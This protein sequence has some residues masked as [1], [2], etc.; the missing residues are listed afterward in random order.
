MTY[1]AT[2]TFTTARP[3]TDTERHDLLNSLFYAVEDP[4]DAEGDH[5][6]WSTNS[7]PTITLSV[8]NA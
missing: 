3:L 7:L 1:T 5:A 2:I 4:T 6:D 8:P